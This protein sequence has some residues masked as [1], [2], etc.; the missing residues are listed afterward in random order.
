MRDTRPT[1]VRVES[2][3]RRVLPALVGRAVPMSG[4][5]TALRISPSIEVA[6]LTD[7]MLPRLGWVRVR[8]KGSIVR[9]AHK[10][11]IPD[12]FTPA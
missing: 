12:G 11:H 5:R 6:A 1:D 4:I 3:L 7:S 10:D 8:N 9:W 2:E